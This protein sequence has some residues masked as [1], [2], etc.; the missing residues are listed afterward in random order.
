VTVDR[1][2]VDDMAQIMAA[3]NAQSQASF[4][5]EP[6][7]SAALAE[8]VAPGMHMSIPGMEQVGDPSF[9]PNAGY[10]PS[11]GYNPYA[12]ASFDPETGEA[13]NGISYRTPVS[14]AETDDM[15]RIMM[16]LSGAQEAPPT[17]VNDPALAEAVATERTPRGARIGSWEIVIKEGKSRKSYDVVSEDGETVIA[18][19]LYVY[20]AAYGI[21]KRLNEGVAINDPKIRTLLA[22]EEGFAK[23]TNDAT[24]YR[25]RAKKA[26]E[27]GDVVRQAVAEDRHDEAA[28]QAILD[29]NEILR[30]AGLLRS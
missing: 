9:D 22:L 30:L 27:R 26:S 2:A 21:A 12:S 5:A 8:D 25:E 6:A 20:D 4:E 19:D 3:L 16:A 24:V 18:R 1:K 7:P 10:D 14:S 28:R 11:E 13:P 23:K 17:R 15:K 29:H